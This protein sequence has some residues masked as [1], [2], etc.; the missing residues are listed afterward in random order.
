M[1]EIGDR[2]DRHHLLILVA[3]IKIENVLRIQPELR[4]GLGID[5]VRLA[6]FV[7]LVD[8][9]RTKIG[10][11]CREDV[12]NRDFQGFGAVAIDSD[13]DLRRRQLKRRKRTLYRRIGGGEFEDLPRQFI[14]LRI[15]EAAAKQLDLHLEAARLADALDWRR[16][17]HKSSSIGKIVEFAL[18]AFK[19]RS[20]ILILGL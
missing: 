5:L 19:D 4:I 9:G 3:H 11:Q 2:A 6:E 7:E 16:H 12:A 14:E 15:I 13:G 17:Q 10:A 18:N 20:E 1:A 8:V